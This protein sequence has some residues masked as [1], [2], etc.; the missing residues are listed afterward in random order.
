M[1]D[2][3]P[4]FGSYRVYENITIILNVRDLIFRSEVHKNCGLLRYYTVCSGDFTDASGQHIGP[5]FKGRDFALKI[6]SICCP[7]TSARN[8]QYTVRTAPEERS[9][10]SKLIINLP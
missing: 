1:I 8:H 3:L 4:I 7:E 2:Y 10:H 5:V 6:R 9:S